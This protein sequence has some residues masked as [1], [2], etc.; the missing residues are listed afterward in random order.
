MRS[1]LY[2]TVVRCQDGIHPWREACQ[3]GGTDLLRPR[4]SADRCRVGQDSCHEVVELGGLL[5]QG[6]VPGGAE[7]G[8]V[9]R[10]RAELLEPLLGQHL[11]AGCLVAHRAR[12]GTQRAGPAAGPAGPAARPRSRDR[13]RSTPSPPPPVMATSFRSPVVVA[14]NGAECVATTVVVYWVARN[15]PGWTW[16]SPA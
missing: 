12:E 14:K 11:P 5:P 6:S 9:L 1:I 8:Q 7:P 16:L 3:D 13:P 10:R 4:R 2:R 15:V